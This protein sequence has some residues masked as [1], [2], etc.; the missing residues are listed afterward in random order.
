MKPFTVAL[1][2][3]FIGDSVRGMGTVPGRRQ[4]RQASPIVEMTAKEELTFNG[5]EADDYAKFKEQILPEIPFPAM[6]KEIALARFF[7][8]YYLNSTEALRGAR[9][10]LKWRQENHMDYLYKEDHKKSRSNFEASTEV[11]DVKGRP[12]LYM[13]T[14]KW[15]LK[16]AIIKGNAVGYERAFYQL[17]DETAYKGVMAN[18]AGNEYAQYL[19]V[20]NYDKWTLAE[21]GCADCVAL[22][23][24]LGANFDSSWPLCSYKIMLINVSEDFNLFLDIIRLVLSKD[25]NAKLAV[26][27]RKKDDWWKEA[28]ALI[29]EADLKKTA[30]GE[31]E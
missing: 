23:S 26:F 30:S 14:G 13:E 28:T 19:M 22:V 18:E 16:E 4:K 31:V 10:V 9:A 29:A 6:K 2:L 20:L 12:V 5:A 7:R 11:S 3:L 17:L 8:S 1:A 25:T 24:S 27:G 21:G 15:K